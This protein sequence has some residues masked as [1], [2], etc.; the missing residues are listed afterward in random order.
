MCARLPWLN[1]LLQIFNHFA[2]I[3]LLKF[4]RSRVFPIRMVRILIKIWPIYNRISFI[5]SYICYKNFKIQD[6]NL[7]DYCNLIEENETEM[8][9]SQF[10]LIATD[11]IKYLKDHQN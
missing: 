5:E 1:S 7:A 6:S 11:V 9:P 4:W 10:L 3:D 2:L 8:Q